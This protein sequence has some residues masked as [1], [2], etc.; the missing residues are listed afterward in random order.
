MEALILVKERLLK[1]KAQFSRPPCTNQFRFHG[2]DNANITSFYNKTSSIKR[3]NEEVNCT[4]P[5]PLVGV[6]CPSIHFDGEQSI[7][8]GL[9]V[10][11][12]IQTLNFRERRKTQG[13]LRKRK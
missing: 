10:S 8:R 2:F 1:G 13:Q 3:R 5:S 7:F 4:V 6:T 9:S 11:G 12:L